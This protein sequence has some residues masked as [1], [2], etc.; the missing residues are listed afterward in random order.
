MVIIPPIDMMRAPP[1]APPRGDS[2][3]VVNARIAGETAHQPIDAGAGPDSFRTAPT[4]AAVTH[5]IA[6]S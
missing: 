6:S 3:P 2:A 5:A 4:L 1:L